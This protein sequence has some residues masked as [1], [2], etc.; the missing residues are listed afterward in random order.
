MFFVRSC[1]PALLWSRPPTPPCSA[2]SPSSPSN[3]VDADAPRGER[4]LSTLSPPGFESSSLSFNPRGSDLLCVQFPS[5]VTLSVQVS[6]KLQRWCIKSSKPTVPGLSAVFSN[7][8]QRPPND[9][10][11]ATDP[12]CRMHP[13]PLRFPPLTPQRHRASILI[14]AKTAAWLV[15]SFT[16][17]Y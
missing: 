4:H 9:V 2:I 7:C 1:T 12:C 17:L 3:A 15:R 8:W 13:W 16:S 14:A 10:V 6:E 5:S 11:T